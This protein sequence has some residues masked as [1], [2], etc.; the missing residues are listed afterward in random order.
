MRMMG[1]PCG[2][3]F[4][5]P[6][7]DREVVSTNSDSDLGLATCGLQ[8]DIR[9]LRFIYASPPTDPCPAFFAS[10]RDSEYVMSTTSDAPAANVST[11]SSIPHDIAKQ[12]V[13][14]SLIAFNDDLINYHPA[15]PRLY[16]MIF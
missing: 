8:T 1:W 3:T 6:T 16:A 10:L 15:L 7:L 14:L 13:G 5:W 2:L 4:N 11:S 12:Y 9:L